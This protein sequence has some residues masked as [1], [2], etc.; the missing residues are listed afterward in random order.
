MPVKDISYSNPISFILWKKI[1]ILH[2]SRRAEKSCWNHSS[3]FGVFVHLFF[4]PVMFLHS[5]ELVN[6]KVNFRK[7]VSGSVFPSSLHFQIQHWTSWKIDSCL[8]IEEIQGLASSRA[9]ILSSKF[10]ILSKTFNHK[11]VSLWLVLTVYRCVYIHSHM[12]PQSF[13]CLFP[14]F[15]FHFLLPLKKKRK[16]LCLSLP[17]EG[18]NLCGQTGTSFFWSLFLSWTPDLF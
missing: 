8:L 18:K 15:G 13:S 4:S 2:F 7:K 10:L 6:Q 12:F 3:F 17:E 16:S 14:F 5:Q 11:G 1:N 9:W